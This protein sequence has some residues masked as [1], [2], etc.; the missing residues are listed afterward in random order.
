MEYSI[1]VKEANRIN[2][3]KG[4]K[5]LLFIR[6]FAIHSLQFQVM[7]ER[8][9]TPL[10]LLHYK[11]ISI[12]IF[13]ELALIQFNNGRSLTD[14]PNAYFSDGF[15]FVGAQRELESIF[16]FFQEVFCSKNNSTNSNS[17]HIIHF[18][19]LFPFQHDVQSALG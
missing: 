15:C 11:L 16:P 14:S 2:D 12:S 17:N 6:I 19:K 3:L 5:I 13:E 10:H 7:G 18:T 4:Q 8:I 1:F 9:L